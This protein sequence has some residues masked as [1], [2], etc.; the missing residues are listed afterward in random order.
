M[1]K[2]TMDCKTTYSCKSVVEKFNAMVDFFTYARNGY[3]E[4][5]AQNIKYEQQFNIIKSICQK[6][7]NIYNNNE[8]YED[9][10]DKFLGECNIAQQILEVLK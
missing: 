5:F 9:D 8:F 7:V 1:S 4:M 10:S 6:A 2:I 3:F